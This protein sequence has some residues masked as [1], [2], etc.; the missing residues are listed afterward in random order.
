MDGSPDGIDV[1]DDASFLRHQGQR[2]Q[3]RWWPKKLT[4]RSTSICVARSR[5]PAL[6][7]RIMRK[8]LPA[9]N[10]N[11]VTV[12]LVGQ[13]SGLPG[14]LGSRSTS[15]TLRL[16]GRG[17]RV[18]MCMGRCE[19]RRCVGCMLLVYSRTTECNEM[20]DQSSCIIYI[21]TLDDSLI[22]RP[23]GGLGPS[24]LRAKPLFRTA[25]AIEPSRCFTRLP[26]I[27]F[28]DYACD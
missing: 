5:K 14:L 20:T 11:W 28:I 9:R 16:V 12:R 19:A 1:Y 24:S 21:D 18:E 13:R 3:V 8:V 17:H 6:W 26:Q 2:V 27:P 10:V 15:G 22:H 7:S 25:I 23:R 4:F